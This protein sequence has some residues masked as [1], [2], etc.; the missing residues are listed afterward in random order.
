MNSDKCPQG[1][2]SRQSFRLAFTLVELLVVLAIIGIL[3]GILLPAVQNV[4]EAARRVECSNKVRQLA[5]GMINRRTGLPNASS[6]DGFGQLSSEVENQFNYLLICPTSS[7]RAVADHPFGKGPTAVS[8]FLYVA[9]GTAVRENAGGQ[10]VREPSSKDPYDGFKNQRQCRDGAS[11]T[12]M[13]CEAISDFEIRSASGEDAVD[14]WLQ[15]L[16]EESSIGGSTGVP[17]NGY[18]HSAGFEKTEIGF[19]SRHS[20]GGVNAG[21][22]DG[23]V[24]FINDSID[25]TAWSGLGTQAGGEVVNDW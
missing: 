18:K 8:N 20:G 5:L 25:A 23:H 13:Y 22:A 14:H 4:R 7:E 9:S 16:G 1:L 3:I 11:N 12:V 15:R 2:Q 19:S 10:F 6:S 17:I 21:F 24:V